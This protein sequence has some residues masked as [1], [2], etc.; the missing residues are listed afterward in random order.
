L[1]TPT[2][3]SETE[4]PGAYVD[5]PPGAY[6]R[7]VAIE[8]VPT[9][10][11]REALQKLHRLVAS[12]KADDPLVPVTVLVPS[13]YV[14]VSARRMLASGRL[15]PIGAHSGIAGI[16][17]LTTYRLAEL[18]GAPPLAALGRRPLSTPVV[19]AA[20]R[21]VL[22]EMTTM[23]SAVSE[24]PSTE[25]ALVRVHRELRDLTSAEL[26]KL[27]EQSD[28]AREVVSI[29]R[30]AVIRLAPEWY[31]EFDLFDAATTIV[32]TRPHLAYERGH[33]IVYLPQKI[34]AAGVRL[35]TAIAT[36]TQLTILAGFTGA[37]E[38]DRSINDLLT[39]LGA[40]AP[41]M[42]IEPPAAS[43]IV[44]V[45]DADDEVRAVIRDV[46]TA[47]TEGV[48][49]ESMAILHGADE[50]YARLLE[51][52]LVAAELPHNG[53]SVRTVEESVI[54][55]TV[56]ALLE[57][58]DRGY[59]R[60]DVLGLVAST[61]IRELANQSALVPANEWERISRDSGI[62][63]GPEE[64]A[65]RLD[66]FVDEKES[67]IDR[68]GD[69]P[70]DGRV[71]RARRNSSQAVRMKTFVAEL[72]ANTD[73]SAVPT[74]WT[75]KAAW[76]RS[77]ITRYLG[78]EHQ[79]TTWPEVELLAAD[80]L[81]GA[82]DRL[83]GLDQV[84]T[85]PTIATFRRSLE[86]ELESGLGRSGQFGE[87][88][89]VGRVGQALGIDLERVF[90]LGLAEGTLPGRHRDDSLLPDHERSQVGGALQLASSRVGEQHRSYLAALANSQGPRTIYFP[91]GDLRKSTERMPSRWLLDSVESLHGSRVWSDEFASLASTDPPWLTEVSSFIGGLRSTAFPATDQEYEL[92]SLLDHHE[93]G[94]DVA[95]HHLT[96]I[97]PAFGAGVA[98]LEA[99]ASRRF[100][101]FDGNLS[102][103]I[104]DAGVRLDVVSPTRLESWAKCPH[105]YFMQDVL[106]VDTIEQPESLLQISPMDRGNLVHTALD[107]F[108]TELLSSDNVQLPEP[109]QPWPQ[110]LRDLLL[111]TAEQLCDSYADRGLVGKQLFWKQ[112]RRSLIDDLV[113]L[114]ERDTVRK[115]RGKIVASELG[116]GFAGSTSPPVAHALTD[117]RVISFRGSADRV[118]QTSTGQLI[119]IDYKTGSASAFRGL[120]KEEGDP[121][122]SGTKL[123]LPIYAL[124]SRSS[125]GSVETP[126]HAAY[127]F[128]SSKGEFR[129]IGYDVDD[130]VMARFDEV[131]TT[132][133][134]GIS[135]G[136]FPA[137]PANDHFSYYVDCEYCD[138]DG[139]GALARRREWERKRDD[140]MLS[141]YRMLAEPDELLD[142]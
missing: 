49:L 136:V 109:G 42:S 135:A 52:Q 38:A 32:T 95:S 117:G 89:F 137:R 102:D 93:A 98:L 30:A 35:L 39:R 113:E 58:P 114:L 21:G 112:D 29:H 92:R 14:G 24:H 107:Q 123:Q 101:R 75:E 90:V 63:E 36:Q 55:R 134:N 106:R 94:Q 78:P 141:E 45:S 62:V 142:A 120:D 26:S 104:T 91:R 65:V 27:A 40:E 73:S 129:W 126:V 130:R 140:P 50:P 44:S 46:M 103:A 115:V 83:A 57:L 10:Y 47:M 86:L 96:S 118:E 110:K 41:A 60:T 97:D 25:R 12:I 15:G 108:L 84:E 5:V 128:I 67:E 132:I 82:L 51:E 28:R 11:G 61:P 43:R 4:R 23:F 1:I 54:G 2:P 64:W 133:I 139:L 69:D 125:H 127:W 79:R 19:A 8:A 3:Q 105:K 59:R 18:F 53:A 48:A 34:T 16:D 88:V 72:V 9:P 31:D 121:V 76:L 56:M 66:R 33:V 37:N 17:L 124:A 77:L 116:F 74:T 80:I 7:G 99:R 87:G 71:R 122:A 111:E 20:I 100:T 85:D 68:L 22:R 81:D 131:L 6:G 138:P 70:D 13:N 119:V